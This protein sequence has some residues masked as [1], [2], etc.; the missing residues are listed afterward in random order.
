MSE[1]WYNT[2]TGEVEEGMKSPVIDRAGPFSSRE[3]AL[4]A[5]EIIAERSR[6]WAEEEASDER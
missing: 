4:R 2:R 5:P 6:L 3:E 1:W